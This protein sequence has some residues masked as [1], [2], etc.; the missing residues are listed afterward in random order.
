M[1]N[2][3]TNNYLN[4]QTDAKVRE[5]NPEQGK[6]DLHRR[7]P[8]LSLVLAFIIV[9]IAATVADF[10]R[11]PIMDEQ[12]E[13]FV[14]QAEQAMDAAK[15]DL[16]L[17]DMTPQALME[18]E[19]CSTLKDYARST[20][21]D[22]TKKLLGSPAVIYD[23]ESLKMEEIDRLW[24]AWNEQTTQTDLTA[25]LAD[26]VAELVAE[27]TLPGLESSLWLVVTSDGQRYILAAEGD[28]WGLCPSEALR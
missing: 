15:P 27:Q 9:A 8:L 4:T 26:A 5:V 28:L 14:S 12:K 10:R 24:Q 18:Q 7:N 19:S 13:V 2:N 6:K 1:R 21:D 17:G 22:V 3:Y 11:V 16:W 23:W 25:Y 20:M